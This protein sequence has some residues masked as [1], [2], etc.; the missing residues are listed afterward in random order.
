[1]TYVLIGLVYMIGLSIMFYQA[2]ALDEMTML[3]HGRL[4]G[5][6]K[7]RYYLILCG[8]WPVTMWIQMYFRW[9]VVR[10]T[11]QSMQGR[12]VHG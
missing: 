3:N 11:S 12:G 7:Y 4:G 10:D 8:F 2:M 5:L 6:T 1:M 9:L